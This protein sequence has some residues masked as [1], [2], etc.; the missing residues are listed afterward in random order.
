MPSTGCIRDEIHLHVTSHAER[1]SW[2]GSYLEEAGPFELS[3]PK[4]T[5]LCDSL[6]LGAVP[7]PEVPQRPHTDICHCASQGPTMPAVMSALCLS[8]G[9]AIWRPHRLP[10]EDLA[11]GGPPGALQ[12]SGPRLPAPGPPHHSKHALLGIISDSSS[13][14][15]ILQRLSLALPSAHVGPAAQQRPGCSI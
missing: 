11:A 6:S 1:L 3:H 8:P 15:L 13:R 9:Q 7:F 12:G 14:K 10:G 2:G 4:G 5:S